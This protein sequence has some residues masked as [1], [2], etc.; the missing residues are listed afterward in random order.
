MEK[1]LE[2]YGKLI[3]GILHS[4]DRILITGHLKDFYHYFFLEKD[5]IKL[6]DFKQYVLGVTDRIKAHIHW[7]IE[8]EN[9]YTGYLT[10]ATI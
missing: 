4:P 9:C 8:R 10:S 2:H 6:K 7:I 1:F 5:N 3:N